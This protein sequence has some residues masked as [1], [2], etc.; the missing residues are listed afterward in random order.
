MK[1]V[2]FFGI[3]F[4]FYSNI[5][6]MDTIKIAKMESPDHFLAMRVVGAA[7]IRLN[8]PIEFIEL[9]GPRALESSS[10]GEIDGELSRIYSVGE[11]YPTLIRVP[12]P[13]SYFKPSVF[14]KNKHIKVNGWSSLKGYDIGFM[15]GMKYAERG[16]R[17]HDPEKLSISVVERHS[18]LMLSKNRIDIAISSQINGLIILK[19]LKLNQIHCL[20][21]PLERLLTYHYLHEKNKK[22]IPKLDKILKQMVK[23]GEMERMREDFLKEI[24]NSTSN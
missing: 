10:R 24:S 22:L 20:K 7:Y 11:K 18:F 21:P 16:L 15:R 12:T 13:I 9:P 17:D 14:S 5:Y 2:V 6:S 8:I 19:K 4:F 23:R 1:T 3:C